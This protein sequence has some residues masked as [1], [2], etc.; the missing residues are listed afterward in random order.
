MAG[1]AAVQIGTYN[2]MNLRGGGTLA[3]ELL[4]LME[5]EGIRSLEEIRGI[6]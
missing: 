5:R 3:N 6:V 4:K 2:F 1:A